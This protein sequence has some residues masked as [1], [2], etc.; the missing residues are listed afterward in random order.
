MGFVV[1]KVA[2]GKGFLRVLQFSLANIIP[3]WLSIF[4]YNLSDE[5]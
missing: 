2:L 3:P 1:E 5:Q 4:I